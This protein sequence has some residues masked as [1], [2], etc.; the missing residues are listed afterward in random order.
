MIMQAKKYMYIEHQYPFQNFTLTYYMCEALKANP[1]LKVVIVTPIK[2]DLPSG[3]VGEIF[4][5]SQDHSMEHDGDGCDD[6]DGDGGDGDDCDGGAG[7][8]GDGDG[9]GCGVVLWRSLTVMVIA[10]VFFL[11]CSH[12]TLAHD[13]SDG[14]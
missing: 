9:V 5:W 10:V 12:R 3:L 2:T 1:Q 7:D 4:D 14:T 11:W 13:L 6:G 8:D